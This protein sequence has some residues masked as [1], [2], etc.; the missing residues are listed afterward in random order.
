M[1]P[2]RG[3]GAACHC[4]CPTHGFFADGLHNSP[5]LW[6]S[7][8]AMSQSGYGAMLG[9]SSSP[10]PQSTGFNS[11][12]QHE[13][14]VTCPHG[15]VTSLSPSPLVAGLG[16]LGPAPAAEPPPAFPGSLSPLSPSLPELPA[17]F[18]R[19]ER[20]TP[21]CV[22]LLLSLHSV[23]SVQSHPPDQRHRQHDGYGQ[24]P[25]SPL[26]P[27]PGTGSPGKTRQTWCLTHPTHPDPFGTSCV[28]CA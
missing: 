23:R 22:R 12:H 17:A 5:D 14:M 10:L 27:W 28:P 16:H 8:G 24:S 4:P 25:E 6:S 26:T 3:L 7:P 20:W 19:G 1:S 15:C 2:S 21:L 11:L 18:R 13:R 9:S